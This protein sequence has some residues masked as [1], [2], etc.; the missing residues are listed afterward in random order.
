MIFSDSVVFPSFWL[1]SERIDGMTVGFDGELTH[2]TKPTDITSETK[3]QT[4]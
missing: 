3:S 4:E 1:K 2:T